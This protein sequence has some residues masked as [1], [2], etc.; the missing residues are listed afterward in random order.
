M[1][2]NSVFPA[3][4]LRAALLWI[5]RFDYRGGQAV[6]PHRHAFWQCVFAL[7]GETHGESDGVSWALRAGELVF[8]PPECRHSWEIPRKG[9]LE[10]LDMKF[11][12]DSPGFVLPE[13]VAVGPAPRPDLAAPFAAL[14]ETAETA[15]AFRRERC[16]A[17]LKA[18]LLQ[19]VEGGTDTTATSKTPPVPIP[20]KADPLVRRLAI[21]MGQQPAGSWDANAISRAL[22]YSYRLIGER[23]RRAVG[24]TPRELLRS[25]RMSRA[26]ELLLYSDYPI[27]EIAA[28]TGFETVHHFSR[29]F[30]RVHD[31][32]PAQWKAENSG[33]SPH[34]IAIDP[35]FTN[36][37]HLRAP[38]PPRD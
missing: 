23:C 38:R 17:L 22:G 33:A 25:I 12:V 21:L 2:R 11:Q 8:F 32:A 16:A 9:T 36:V 19:W 15:R 30:K 4:G 26:R 18:F 10:T 5:A 1:R 13:N 28:R 31:K 37:L 6:S 34:G 3:G 7:R 35:G 14:L 29:T 27:K 24:M 20:G